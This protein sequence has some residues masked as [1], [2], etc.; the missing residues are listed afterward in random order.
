VARIC[1]SCEKG[2]IILLSKANR[3]Y[4][5]KGINLTIPD[6]VEVPTCNKCGAE[7]YNS[8]TVE[9]INKMLEKEYQK[10]G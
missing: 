5:Y 2:E 3:K 1:I 9:K 7:W 8:E 4:K 6:L 10:K